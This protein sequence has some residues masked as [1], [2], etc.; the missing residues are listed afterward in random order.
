MALLMQIILHELHDDAVAE[1]MSG[2]HFVD[3]SSGVDGEGEAVTSGCIA[4][5]PQL[6]PSFDNS[7]NKALF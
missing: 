6:D 4:E 7:I 5:A 2:F 3:L 1:I